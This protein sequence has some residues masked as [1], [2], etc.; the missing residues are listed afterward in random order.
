M[1]I[2]AKKWSDFNLLK[3][4]KIVHQSEAFELIFSKT[5]ALRSSEVV[6]CH[7]RSLEVKI[8]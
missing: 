5:L 3:S 2:I 6:L 7:P 8:A 4:E 1:S